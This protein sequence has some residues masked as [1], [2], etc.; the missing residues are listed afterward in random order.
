RRHD[1]EGGREVELAEA[2][3]LRRI[4][5]VLAALGEAVELLLA[6]LAHLEHAGANQ[7]RERVALPLAGPG[8][9]PRAALVAVTPVLAA[10]PAPVHRDQRA[11]G[12]PAVAG[13]VDRPEHP[14]RHREA[15][16]E[17]P[18]DEIALVLGLEL[19]EL[20]HDVAVERE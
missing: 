13:G 18:E 14:L 8:R 10:L 1:L 4:E 20:L 5:Q 9:G 19:E 12:D 2:L 3:V 6:P 17:R 11:L 7:R 15:L 16:V